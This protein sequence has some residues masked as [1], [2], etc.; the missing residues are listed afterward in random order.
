MPLA[1]GLA[2]VALLP[3]AILTVP[4]VANYRKIGGLIKAMP[5]PLPANIKIAEWSNYDQSLSFY[6]NRRIILI[7]EIDELA[8]GKSLDG[9]SEFFLK[10]AEKPE[11]TCRRGPLLVNLR[12]EAWSRVR[13]WGLLH[14]VAVNTT[15]VRQATTDFFVSPALC[16]G[17]MT[18]SPVS[19]FY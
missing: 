8:F 5:N 1:T 14:P 18:A 13:E 11:T 16:P 12:P 9:N 19:P 3:T 10:G 4:A 2:L 15:N 17:P 7:D 6:T